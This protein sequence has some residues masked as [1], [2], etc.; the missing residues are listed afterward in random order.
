[1]KNKPLNPFDPPQTHSTPSITSMK[2][3]NITK[4]LVTG[5]FCHFM[6]MKSRKNF[7]SSSSVFK[8]SKKMTRKR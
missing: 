8:R 4:M 1:M 3:K 2:V 5:K 6:L 7:L